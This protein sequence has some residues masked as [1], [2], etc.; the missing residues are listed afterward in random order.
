MRFYFS[1]LP[2]PV[3]TLLV[4]FT[5]VAQVS[6]ATSV[7]LVSLAWLPSVFWLMRRTQRLEM[8][9]NQALPVEGSSESGADWREALAIISELFEGEIRDVYEEIGRVRALVSEAVIKLT[10]SFEDLG[11]QTRSNEN[12]VHEIIS[13][14]AGVVDSPDDTD[15]RLNFMS[16]AS[17]LLE[18][19]IATLVDISKQSVHTVHKIDDMVDQMDNIFSL[20]QNVKGI[21]DQTNLLALNA[22]IEAARA[23]EFGRGFA[24][25][26]DE[27]RLL[28]HRSASMNDEIRECVAAGKQSIE[29]VRLT[30]GEMAARDMN[31][32]IQIKE[33]VDKAFA[34]ADEFNSYLSQRI[35]DLSKVSEGI[36]ASVGDAVRSLQFEDIVVQSLQAADRHMDRLTELSEI[37]VS[38]RQ[39]SVD[40]EAHAALMG[41]LH[42]RLDELSRSWKSG[43]AKAVNQTSMQAGGVEL[44]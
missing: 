40:Q 27:V 10:G 26:A 11:E 31:E 35:T 30:V 4:L 22:A 21:A 16:E 43:N 2:A 38:L 36:D 14:Q 29:V 18:K 9:L 20:L 17:E 5:G 33:R 6:P 8:R 13:R 37:L 3:A 23:G 39:K 34:D 42:G 12:M 41:E 7:V 28:S 19:F 25:V 15:D 24:V 1:F 32:T 44:F